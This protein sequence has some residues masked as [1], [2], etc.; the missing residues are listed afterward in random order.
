[1][2][3]VVDGAA[4][5]LEWISIERLAGAD[6]AVWKHI[7]LAQ[8]DHTELSAAVAG[9]SA[10]AELVELPGH[11]PI[12]LAD[13]RH[14]HPRLRAAGTWLGWVAAAVLAFGFFRGVPGTQPGG[15]N[16]ASLLPSPATSSPDV[17]SL[18]SSPAEA[19]DLYLTR[20][21]QTGQVVGELPEKV[22][23]EARPMLVAGP[24]GSETTTEAGYEVYY[25]RQ[26]VERATVPS[27]YQFSTDDTGRVA[28]PV[29]VPVRQAAPSPSGPM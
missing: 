21:Q 2:S 7:A 17:A 24:A 13:R 26:I 14:Q 15:V 22:L 28:L 23:L 5:R 4:G 20:G 16:S 6:P 9:A 3:R 27:L 10:R 18:I 12:R 8:R 25:L 11:E 19:L 1:V 29:R